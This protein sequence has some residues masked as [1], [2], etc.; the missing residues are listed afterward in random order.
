MNTNGEKR[1]LLIDKPVEE[2]AKVSNQLKVLQSNVVVS[3]DTLAALNAIEEKPHA[4]DLIVIEIEMPDISGIAFGKI[5]AIQYPHIP[6]IFISEKHF[7]E[8]ERLFGCHGIV[9]E[10]NLLKRPFT[11]T[12]LEGAIHANALT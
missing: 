5:I 7:D 2:R 4:F 9:R 8:I 1:V 6:V 3:D 12:E 10:K 11:I